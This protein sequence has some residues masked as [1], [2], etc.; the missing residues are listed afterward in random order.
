M[1]VNFLAL[2]QD[3][4][5]VNGLTPAQLTVWLAIYRECSDR[6]FLEYNRELMSVTCPV[7]LLMSHACGMAR[8][9]FSEAR[10]ALA[11]K[12]LL[13]FT[14]G[15]ERGR[16]GAYSLASLRRKKGRVE[17]Y[18]PEN[19]TAGDQAKGSGGAA[20]G[21]VSCPVGGQGSS[22]RERER[23][24]RRK[25]KLTRQNDYAQRDY[26][27]VELGE[28][29]GWMA[30]ES[31]GELLSALAPFGIGEGGPAQR[32]AERALEKSCI[33][34]ITAQA[35]TAEGLERIRA[36]IARC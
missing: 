8:S 11:E 33:R 9:T 30:G 13:R 31:P 20:S 18:W 35:G 3:Y 10:A 7:E 16:A 24:E 26:S 34:E 21:A 27:D 36:E 19:R 29:P 17:V 32:W 25:E 15:P 14:P 2:A 12:G 5:A 22:I 4:A 23:G 28:T 6:G 1:A